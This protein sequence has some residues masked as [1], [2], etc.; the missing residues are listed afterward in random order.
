MD[1]MIA[2]LSVTPLIVYSFLLREDGKTSLW[3]AE[4][5]QILL[6]YLRALFNDHANSSN[7][8]KILLTFSRK[9]KKER[10][11][12]CYGRRR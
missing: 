5:G 11:Y 7:N 2:S 3:K 6:R 9:E 12:T 10:C 8:N 1:T 4:T